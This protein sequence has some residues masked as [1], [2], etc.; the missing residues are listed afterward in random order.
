M[1]LMVALEEMS[2]DHRS[3]L[4]LFAGD[5]DSCTKCHSDALSGVYQTKMGDTV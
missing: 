1:N 2:E 4:C 3:Q 5:R